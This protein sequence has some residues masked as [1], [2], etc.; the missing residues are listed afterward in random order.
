VI[1][2]VAALVD[3]FDDRQTPYLRGA[4]AAAAAALFRLPPSR[5][6]RRGGDE[7]DD[8]AVEAAKR[9]QRRA[10]RPEESVW[11][12]ASAGTGK[13]KV[14]TDRLLALMLD[15][16]DPARILCLT[17][18]R[19]A[20]A[21]MA[22]R[23]NQRLA[24]WTTLPPG[25]LAE[26]LV[27]LTGR[28][29]QEHEIARARQLF[30]RVLD[31]PG[32]TKIATIHAFCQSLLRRFPLEAGVP[33]EFA[34]ID[35][36]SAGRRWS[37]RGR[38]DPA[39]GASARRGGSPSA[40]GRRRLC[41]EERF[42]E[43]MGDIAATAA[44]CAGACGRRERRC[45]ARLCDRL[46]GAEAPPRTSWSRRSAP[47]APATKPGCALAAAALAEGSPTDAARPRSS[48]AGARA[49][50]SARSSSTV[51]RA[52]PDRAGQSARC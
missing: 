21:E 28:F 44:N 51:S 15:G 40:G 47:A 50:C 22:N 48:R 31:M 39:R 17:F 20:A 8:R 24:A 19:A 14:L 13:T 33:P 9:A 4:G 43:L 46:A 32:G 37:R 36:R 18:T 52:L 12:A 30:A 34:V 1:A 26:E 49:R 41:A 10:L 45:A 25:A 11:V 27:E 29:P 7:G 38:R 42:F 2:E 3:R 6:A 16:T 23:I 5:A 35:E